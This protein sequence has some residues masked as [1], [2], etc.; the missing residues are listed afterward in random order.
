VNDGVYGRGSIRLKDE[1]GVDE[2]RILDQTLLL[3]TL[4]LPGS[5]QVE[6][7]I[8]RWTERRWIPPRCDSS[9]DPTQHLRMTVLINER[10]GCATPVDGRIVAH[11]PRHA[12]DHV[13]PLKVGE[14]EV[15]AF[16]VVAEADGNG[17]NDTTCR[18]CLA[19]GEGDGVGRGRGHSETVSLGEARRGEQA[20]RAAV[21]KCDC[22]LTGDEAGDLDERVTGRDELVDL[23]E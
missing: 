19:V 13:V 6:L 17:R 21:Q 16:G 11:E 7:E 3:M 10:D 12:E 23:R 1:L 18:L 9:G 8:R 4:E 5:D 15:Q 22:G 2:A 14:R 20:S